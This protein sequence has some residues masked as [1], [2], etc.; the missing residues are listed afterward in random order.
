VSGA[1]LISINRLLHCLVSSIVSAAVVVVLLLW[2]LWLILEVLGNHVTDTE[3]F[4]WFFVYT[5][6]YE[7][8]ALTYIHP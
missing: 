3:Y 4:T 7:L 5:P 2:Q 1:G 8:S 6:I